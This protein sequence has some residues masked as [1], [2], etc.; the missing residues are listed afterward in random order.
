MAEART[1]LS[2]RDTRT[3]PPPHRFFLACIPE[4]VTEEGWTERGSLGQMQL[5]QKRHDESDRVYVHENRCSFEVECYARRQ[6]TP[7][8]RT[9]AARC[10]RPGPPRARGVRGGG[11]RKQAVRWLPEASCLLACLWLRVPARA[12]AAVSGLPAGP[13]SLARCLSHTAAAQPEQHR[14]NARTGVHARGTCP[15]ARPPTRASPRHASCAS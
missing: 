7:A 13:G 15:R 4:R 5:L 12:A 8:S 1:T 6:C 10:S 11:F 9:G 3:A 2:A 14:E